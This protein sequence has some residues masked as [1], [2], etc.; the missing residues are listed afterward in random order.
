M[1]KLCLNNLTSFCG[2][3]TVC[4]HERRTVDMAYFEFSKASVTISAVFL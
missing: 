2:E 4:V 3:R 1:Y